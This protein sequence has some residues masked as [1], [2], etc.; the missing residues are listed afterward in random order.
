MAPSPHSSLSITSAGR[1]IRAAVPPF[2]IPYLT[3]TEL[4]PAVT[5]YVPYSCAYCQ[6]TCLAPRLE[7]AFQEAGTQSAVCIAVPRLQ[8]F[9]YKRG[10][11][12]ISA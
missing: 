2:S 9:A 5:T 12:C 11:A 10:T 6:F 3:Y 8:S 7:E 4:S 1:S